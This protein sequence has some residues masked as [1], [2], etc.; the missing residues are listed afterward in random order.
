MLRRLITA[1]TATAALAFTVSLTARAESTPED[2]YE[3]REA[4]MTSLRGHIGAASKIVR[5][6]VEDDGFLLDHATALAAGIAEVHRVFPEGSAVGE[7]EA[8]PVIW[9]DPEGFDEAILNAEEA[10]ENF[11]KVIADGAGKAAI[12]TAFRDLGASCRG[13]HDNFRKGD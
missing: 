1:T 9:E 5:G 11:R 7:S 12:A 6:L 13:C 8:L 2:A 10:A 4:L 3:Y